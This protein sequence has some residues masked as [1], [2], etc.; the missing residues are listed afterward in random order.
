VFTPTTEIVELHT[1]DAVADQL[2]PS[3]GT[4]RVSLRGTVYELVRRDD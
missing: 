3:R 4:L 1:R 2:L